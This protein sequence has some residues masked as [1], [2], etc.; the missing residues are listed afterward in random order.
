LTDIWKYIIR[1]IEVALKTW[2]NV[3][4]AKLE[5]KSAIRNDA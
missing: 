4:S 1:S 5:W 3:I 2:N